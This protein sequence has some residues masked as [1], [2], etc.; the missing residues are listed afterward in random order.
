MSE[1]IIRTQRG[2]IIGDRGFSDSRNDDEVI[3]KQNPETPFLYVK[4]CQ[5]FLSSR[6]TVPLNKK[7]LELTF[8]FH[9]VQ[10]KSDVVI[11]Y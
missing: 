2:R 5:Q 10:W 9:I 1:H 3:P 4:A 6:L 11:P 8:L 7:S